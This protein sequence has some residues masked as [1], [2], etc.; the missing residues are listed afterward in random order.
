MPKP[1]KERAAYKQYS[2]RND[3][4]SVHVD[5]PFVSGSTAAAV[6]SEKNVFSHA[7][8][9]YCLA[10][11]EAQFGPSSPLRFSVSALRVMAEAMRQRIA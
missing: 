7:R 3:E 5:L 4:K 8:H 10:S 11:A 9:S 2:Q 6:L 1:A